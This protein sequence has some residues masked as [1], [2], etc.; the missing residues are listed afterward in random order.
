MAD[1]YIAAE[2]DTAFAAAPVL[3][4]SGKRVYAGPVTAFVAAAMLTGGGV[5][6]SAAPVT[7]F[8]SSPTLSSAGNKIEARPAT[9][10]QASAN[11]TGASD[12]HGFSVCQL[13]SDLLALWGILCIK[14]SPDF[15][16]ARA[17]TD[18]NAALQFVWNHAEDRSFWTRSTLTLTMP[19]LSSTL[20]LDDTIQNVVGPCRLVAGKVPLAQVGSIGEIESF[21]SL[22]LESVT[23]TTPVAYYIERTM[24]AVNDPAKCRLIVFPPTVGST[25]ML[26][27]VVKEAP[28]YTPDDL[29]TC[30]IIPIPHSYVESLLLPIARYQASS[31]YLFRQKDLKETIDREYQQAIASLDAADPLPGKSGDNLERREKKP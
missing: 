3:S 6:V 16:L 23:P 8:G 28:R 1:K 29:A 19:P 31:F 13:V 10:F 30:P 20:D 5:K 27:D 24:Q 17:L 12:L 2:P 15:A 7:A 18:L 22:F 25:A 14:N 11:L 21:G 9:A 4:G 26:L